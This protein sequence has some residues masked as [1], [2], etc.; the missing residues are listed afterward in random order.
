MK[1]HISG[2]IL[3]GF[4]LRKSGETLEQ[5]AQGGGRAIIPGTAQETCRYGTEGHG[6][7]YNIGGTWRVGL[8]DLRD[9]SQL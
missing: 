4:L 5:A 2:W 3:E 6:L 7:V 9:L 1:T 8:Y